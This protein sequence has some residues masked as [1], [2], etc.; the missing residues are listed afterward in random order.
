MS[1]A[2]NRPELFILAFY[3]PRTRNRLKKEKTL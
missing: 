3:N 1:I 2:A